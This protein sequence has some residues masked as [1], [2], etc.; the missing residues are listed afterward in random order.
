MK[1]DP[2]IAPDLPDKTEV[3][4]QCG[5]TPK[6]AALYQQTVEEV[7]KRLKRAEGIQR[8][9]LVLSMLMRLKQL[10]NH[11]S[12]MLNQPDFD[13][14]DSGKFQLLQSLCEPLAERQE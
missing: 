10:C 6:Q 7:A 8:R 3:T 1:T 9:G 5:L 14:Q 13:P 2:G 11:P 12:L 4:V